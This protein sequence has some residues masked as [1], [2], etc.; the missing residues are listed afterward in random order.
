MSDWSYLRRRAFSGLMVAL[1]G[2]S[3][4]L[5]SLVLLVILGYV[6]AKA[7]PALTPDFFTKLPA[8][9]GEPGGGM[10]NAIV[11]TFI[12]VGLACLI[13][14]P[15]GI[16]AGVFLSEYAG[17]RVGDAVRFTADVLTGVPS[18]VT[19]VFVYGLVVL[20]MGTFSALA[21]GIALAIIMLPIVARTSEEALRLLPVSIREAAL[22]LGIPRWR[23]VVSVVIPG[24]L[25]GLTT[26]ALLAVARASGET[27]PLLFTAFGNRFWQN[28]INS[29]IAALPLQ[30]YRY[31]I[32]PYSDWQ[33]QA[34]AASFVLVML[35][36]LLSV[37]TRFVVLRGTGR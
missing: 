21:G 7:A 5:A 33:A 31:G 36:L 3:A 6:I 17:P 20:R 2:L 37:V 19:G 34:W 12:L 4:V 13:G 32:S 18:I 9:V 28:G 23:T 1:C 29:P 10:A 25:R 27:A 14:L 24:A 35:V 8:P 15:V 30:I 16:G 26:G 22:A 11:G